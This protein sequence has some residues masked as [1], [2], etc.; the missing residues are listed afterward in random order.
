MAREPL[1]YQV[2][3]EQIREFATQDR[4]DLL[5][6]VKEVLRAT[7]RPGVEDLR[8]LKRVLRFLR[9]VPRVEILVPFESERTTLVAAVDAD[10][11]G[12]RETR[13]STCGGFIRW[14]RCPVKAWSRTLCLFKVLRTTTH[15]QLSATESA[16]VWM[17]G[18]LPLRIHAKNN[19]LNTCF[20]LV[21]SFIF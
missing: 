8:R 19:F 3:F 11:A 13:R 16:T 9:Q 7:S 15:A 17:K 20:R 14:G 6:A 18:W 1:K 4:P 21:L 2:A 10:F 12:C 5:F